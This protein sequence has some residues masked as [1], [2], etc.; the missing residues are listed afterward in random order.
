MSSHRGNGHRRP[1]SPAGSAVEGALLYQRYGCINRHSPNGLGGVP[2]AQSPD[3]AIPAVSGADF[4]KEFNTNQKIITMIRTG[5]VIGQAPIVSMPHWD[6][7][8]PDEQL[9]ALV[10][11]IKP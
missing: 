4:F 10:A 6:R 1:S 11:Y 2:N 3:K 9:Q 5:S 7:I 8:I